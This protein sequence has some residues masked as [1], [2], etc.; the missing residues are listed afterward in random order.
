MV[1]GRGSQLLDVSHH[2][3]G[4]TLANQFGIHLQTKLI[5]CPGHHRPDSVVR[6]EK[7]LAVIKI[8]G[9]DGLVCLFDQQFVDVV[10]TDLFEIPIAKIQAPT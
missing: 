4:F 1:V 6:I 2:V 5:A 10:T 8:N 7:W 9:G 3:T